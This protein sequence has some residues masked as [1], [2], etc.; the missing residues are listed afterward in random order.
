[1]VRHEYYMSAEGRWSDQTAMP[2]FE[3]YIGD[4]VRLFRTGLGRNPE[5]AAIDTFVTLMEQGASFHDLAHVIAGSA[6]FRKRHGEDDVCTDEFA[7]SLYHNGLDRMP[8]PGGRESVLRAPS[9]GNALEMVAGSEEARETIDLLTALYP[10]GVPL[11]NKLAY[12]LWLE[13]HG[14]LSRKDRRA[15]SRTIDHGMSARPSFSLML[16]AQSDRVDL[17][18]ETAASLERQIYPDWTLGIAYA[19]DAPPGVCAAIMALTRRVPGISAIKVPSHFSQGE[20]WQ[21]LI[22]GSVGDFC[23]FLY[24]SD[25]L[26]PD[27]LYRF[28]AEIATHPY[29]DLLYCD[30]DTLDSDGQRSDPRFKSGWHRDLLYAGDVIGQL[31]MFRRERALLVGGVRH[32]GGE[33]A[34]YELMLRVSEGLPPANVRH[35]PRILYHRGRGPGREPG[36]PRVRA[37]SQHPSILGTVERHLSETHPAIEMRSVYIGGAV[38]PRIVYPLPDELPLVSIVIPTRD[39]GHL[40]E[41]C[42][43]GILGD[44]DYPALEILIADNESRDVETFET[45]RR[46][47]RDPRVKVLQQPGAFNW[48]VINNAMAA[49]S[50]GELLLFLNNDIEILGRDW[51]AEMVRQVLQPDVGVV[52]ARLFYHDGSIQHAGIAVTPAGSRHILRAARDD[53]S[54]YMGQIA[55]ARDVAAVT[56]ACMMVRHT[57]FDAARG[58]DESFP[59]TCNDID[60]CYRVRDAG[61]RVVWTPHAALTHLDGGT[62]G[63]DETAEQIIRTFLDN[64][65]LLERWDPTG[66]GDPYLNANLMVTDHDLLLATPDPMPGAGGML[67]ACAAR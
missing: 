41:T 20:R 1:M 61:Y 24:P 22:D 37:T 64:G 32:D 49:R 17:L 58:F 15:I 52:G 44:T 25:L 43:R 46:L 38:W 36:F 57:V 9:R 18:V 16:L 29:S 39:E 19:A 13:R 50:R 21:E 26:A 60:F 31:A 2:T 53:D 8:D 7:N 45:M 4:V 59:L 14:R 3:S 56:G 51:L 42:V 63:R 34:R 40:L 30:E 11:Q 55:L 35:I 62:R 54:G 27:A 10:E 12:R 67:A 47:G 48:S 66:A 28:A 23:A 6:E 65:R 33:Y 5:Q